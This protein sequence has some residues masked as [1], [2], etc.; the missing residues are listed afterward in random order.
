MIYFLKLLS[1]FRFA[2]ARNK[3]DQI[4]NLVDNMHQADWDNRDI[5]VI[6]FK[7]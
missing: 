7:K 2:N 4:K 1:H 3:P 5:A 6:E